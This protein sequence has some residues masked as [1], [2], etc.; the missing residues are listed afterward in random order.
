VAPY[1]KRLPIYP[2]TLPSLRVKLRLE[3]E[4]VK[5]VGVTLFKGERS[6][7]T[8]WRRGKIGDTGD[9][10][11]SAYGFELSLHKRSKMRTR[12]AS[13]SALLRSPASFKLETATS[14]SNTL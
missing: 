13:S 1:P 14:A 9:R 11:R 6:E 2:N 10:I 8:V 5:S 3:R 7:A 4:L 12:V